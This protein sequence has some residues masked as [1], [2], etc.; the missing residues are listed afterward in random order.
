MI[1]E[2]YNWNHMKTEQNQRLIAVYGAL[3]S[4][5]TL[6]RLMLDAHPSL[7]CPGETDFLFDHLS[8]TDDGPLLDEEALE[9]D[10]IYR[11]RYAQKKL[12]KLD[13]QNRLPEIIQGIEF[14]DGIRQL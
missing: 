13:G 1:D 11:K 3:R 4:G 5:T 8:I 10:R 2:N 6:L 7:S 12:R 14:R 9:Q